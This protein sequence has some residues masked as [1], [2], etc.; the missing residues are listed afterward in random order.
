MSPDN[1]TDPWDQAAE[2]MKG[3]NE[4]IGEIKSASF[5]TGSEAFGQ[6]STFGESCVIVM[7][8]TVE[9]AID[10]ADFEHE[11]TRIILSVG[12][13]ELWLIL[14][15]GAKIQNSKGG[16]L[17]N[18]KYQLFLSRVVKELNVPIKERGASP[19]EAKAWTGLRF[20][21]QKEAQPIPKNLLKEGGKTETYTMLAKQWMQDAL[22]P[23]A[24]GA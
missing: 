14:D 1:N 8:C 11:T 9:Q 19:F 22:P 15:G 12:K 7:E 10:P 18:S 24:V 5:M 6:P 2:G 4:F 3:L 20:H 16:G 23:L 17:G 21:F 13:S